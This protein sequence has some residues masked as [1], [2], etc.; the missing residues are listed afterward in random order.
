MLH[1]RGHAPRRARASRCRRS[2]L[3]PDGQRRGRGARPARP[4]T[5]RSPT[6]RAAAPPGRGTVEILG[7]PDAPT[8]VAAEADRVSGGFARVRWL[9]PAIDGGSPITGY[10]VTVA[11]ARRREAELLRLAVHDHRPRER[12]VL[13]VHGDAPSTPSAAARRARR[14]TPVVPDTLPN[15]V[16][17]VAHGRPRRR[18]ARHRLDR[19][20]QEGQ[21]RHALRGAGHRHHHRRRSSSPSSRLRRCRPPSR[22]WSTTT[23]SPSRSGPR[24]TL[25]YGSVRPGRPDA[26]GRHPAGGPGA[27]PSPTP[28]PDRPQDSARLTIYVGRGAPQRAAADRTTPSTRAST[29]AAWSAIGTTSPSDDARTDTI[30][31]RRPQLPLRR[32]RHQRRDIEGPKANPTSFSLGRHP[33]P[34]RRTRGHDAAV[35]QRRDR[36][37]PAR[38]DSR[39][40]A[41]PS[42]SGGPTTAAPGMCRLQ[43]PRGRSRRSSTSRD[44]ATTRQ[45]LQVRAYNGNTWS[46]LEQPVATSTGPTATPRRRAASTPTATATTS[47]GPGTTGPTAGTSRRSRCRSTTAAG[48]PSGCASRSPSATAHRAPTGSEVKTLANRRAGD[49]AQGQWSPVAGPVG[50]TI[51]DPQPDRHGAATATAHAHAT[52]QRHCT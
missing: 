30:P 17:G 20:R 24:T 52:R 37:G 14:A 1:R 50:A 47:P 36:S 45:T 2:R 40:R 49:S 19:P 9:P 41:S 16:N 4:S 48:S 31:V 43:L 13:H 21:R 44:W 39:P 8:G 23:S 34:S 6:G 3:R 26:V 25:G 12:Q 29:A 11:W 18:L 46:Q 27:R 28:A 10:I 5:S 33:R 32:H 22:A 15:P 35:Q 7:K 42:S 51:P 38:G